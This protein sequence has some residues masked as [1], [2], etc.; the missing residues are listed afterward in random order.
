MCT[1]LNF[2]WINKTLKYFTFLFFTLSSANFL[3]FCVFCFKWLQLMATSN[4]ISS[5]SLCITLYVNNLIIFWKYSYV[6][7]LDFKWRKTVGYSCNNNSLLFESYLIDWFLSHLQ[8]MSIVVTDND[9]SF[10]LWSL[11]SLFLNCCRRSVWGH[12]PGPRGHGWR[13][14]TEQRQRDGTMAGFCQDHFCIS[15]GCQ[16][17][18]F[19]HIEK[20]CPDYL[21]SLS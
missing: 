1:F 11:C 10:S 17:V 20:S 4:P 16:A 21:H 9:K 3:L 7:F 8:I 5:D 19:I 6:H 18:R 2:I 15:V 14:H 12:N 13:K